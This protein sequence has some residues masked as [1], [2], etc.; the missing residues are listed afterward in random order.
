M[1]LHVP[2]SPCSPVED[3]EHGQKGRE[4]SDCKHKI[5]ACTGAKGAMSPYRGGQMTATQQGGGD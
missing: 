5:L 2:E 3:E 4:D 1:T